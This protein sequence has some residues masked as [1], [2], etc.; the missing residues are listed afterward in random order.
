MNERSESAVCVCA[1]RKTCCS[2]GCLGEEPMTGLGSRRERGRGGG[3]S[4]G[5]AAGGGGGGV[6]YGAREEGGL[7][8]ERKA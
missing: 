2:K 7:G 4:T 1:V 6:E 3:G 5:H 8:E